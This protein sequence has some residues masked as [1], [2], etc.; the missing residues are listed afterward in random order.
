MRLPRRD[1]VFFTNFR[2][3][4]PKGREEK[5]THR[6]ESMTLYRSAVL[7]YPEDSG[8]KDLSNDTRLFFAQRRVSK[9][10]AQR[11]KEKECYELDIWQSLLH[12]LFHPVG[13]Y[14]TISGDAYNRL[15][16]ELLLFPPRRPTRAPPSHANK[17]RVTYA[18][19]RVPACGRPGC[20]F[21]FRYD[22]T[23]DY[24]FAV[25]KVRYREE[26]TRQS[27]PGCK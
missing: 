16:L 26:S 20:R 17:S 23:C 27:A 13:R 24:Y 7:E 21:T 6:A 14:T 2:S 18:Y 12:F 4:I 11:T 25:T 9:F 3:L 19:Q 15:I 5:S 10:F 8:E 1:I 22:G